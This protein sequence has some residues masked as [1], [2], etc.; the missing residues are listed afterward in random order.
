MHKS[1]F[2]LHI[3]DIIKRKTKYYKQKFR[4][5]ARAFLRDLSDGIL[6]NSPCIER[7]SEYSSNSFINHTHIDAYNVKSGEFGK[8]GYMTQERRVASAGYLYDAMGNKIQT[9]HLNVPNTIDNLDF[10]LNLF[11]RW[12]TIPPYIYIWNGS[13]DRRGIDYTVFVQHTGWMTTKAYRPFFKGWKYAKSKHP[14]FT[15]RRQFKWKE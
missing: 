2:K 3:D 5:Q 14:A 4:D 1:R 6:A 15:S 7:G 11:G 8:P 9:L 13:I 12:D 10:V